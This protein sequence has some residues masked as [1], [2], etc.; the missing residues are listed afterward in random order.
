M[1]R[2][3]ASDAA[4]SGEQANAA[5]QDSASQ[6]PRDGIGLLLRTIL[7]HHQEL[8]LEGTQIAELSRRY[9]SAPP[10]AADAIDMIE[11]TL[12]AEQFRKGIAYFAAGKTGP[13]AQGSADIGALIKDAVDERTKDKDVVAVD[14]AAK[15]AERLMTWMR[16]FGLFVA[17]PIAIILAGLSFLGI[18]KYQD[19]RDIGTKADATVQAAQQNLDKLTQRSTTVDAQ[20]AQL[21][22]HLASNDQQIK[23]LDTT[24]RNLAEKLSFGTGA[25]LP[26]SLETKLSEAAGRFLG[27]FQQLGYQPKTKTVNVSTKV[28]IANALSYYDPD[29]NSIFV[30]T[31][32]ADDETMVLHEYAHHILYSSLSFDALN[33]NP[34]WKYS[35]VP[36]EFGLADYFVASFRNEPLLGAVAASHSGAA[37]GEKAAYLRN[38]ENTER[39]TAT[40]LGDK[41]DGRLVERLEAAWSGVFWEMRQQLGQQLTDKSLYEAWRSLV[42]QDQATVAHSFIANIAARL[43][44]EAGKPAVK[45]LRDILARRGV[46]GGDLPNTE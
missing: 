30:R 16:L 38:V 4:H 19:V 28:N 10:P 33:G 8:G 22:Q 42:D 17:I 5:S 6:R 1:S 46:S 11:R 44:S 23:Q 26:V 39:I 32:L 20:L 41:F 3:E 14:L 34:Q 31:D 13:A 9:W 40:Q 29:I 27:Y 18:S 21:D 43:D 45:T 35:A 25:N 37:S 2:A 15:A 24:V 36:I 7:E 12:S